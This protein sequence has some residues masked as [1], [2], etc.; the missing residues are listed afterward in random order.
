METLAALEDRQELQD[1][2]LEFYTAQTDRLAASGGPRLDPNQPAKG[3][4]ADL[5]KY[6]PP[7]GALTLARADTGHLLGCGAV[8][9]IGEGV[10][11]FKYLYVKPE[12]RGT[13]LGRALVARRIEIARDMGLR[14]IC[15][16]TLK[17]SVE[18]HALYLSMGFNKVPSFPQSKSLRDIEALAGYMDFYRMDLC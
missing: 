14:Q 12:A 7:T 18:M 9:D 10:A 2:I 1:I 6:F 13:G 11:E 4:W 3:F 8:V 5:N 15:V 17:V 16:D